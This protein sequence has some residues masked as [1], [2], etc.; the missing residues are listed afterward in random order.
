MIKLKES[1][2]I[3][4]FNNEDEKILKLKE[5]SIL[6]NSSKE[7]KKL[8]YRGAY[9]DTSIECDVIGYLEKFTNNN[10]ID[11]SYETAVIK[12]GEE[13]HKINPMLLKDIQESDIKINDL[14]FK[15]E[16]IE[17]NDLTYLE[18]YFNNKSNYDIL[19]IEITSSVL[20][21][22]E[23]L[24]L[25]TNEVTYKH[26]I[27]SKFLIPVKSINTIDDL[28]VIEYKFQYKSGNVICNTTYTPKSKRYIIY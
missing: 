23:T 8:I 17:K 27:S 10:C 18:A 14:D 6:S 13:L 11:M 12:I 26:S 3:I 1:D 9:T 28:S 25:I 19:S 2:N 7:I 24:T 22:N 21:S 20:H 5:W 15:Y 4:K 16:L